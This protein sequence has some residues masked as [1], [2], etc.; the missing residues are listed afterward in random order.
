MV[1]DDMFYVNYPPLPYSRDSSVIVSEILYID[2]A[3]CLAFS[4][5]DLVH[6]TTGYSRTG[7]GTLTATGHVAGAVSA[8]AAGLAAIHERGVQ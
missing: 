2:A 5:C 4:L 8:G 3:R 7:M 6:S 1:T